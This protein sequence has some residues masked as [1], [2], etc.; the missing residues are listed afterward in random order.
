MAAKTPTR[1]THTWEIT[2][3]RER[4]RMLGYVEAPDL[5]TAI[6]VAIRDDEYD[7]LTQD[8]ANCRPT[9]IAGGN[10]AA[11]LEQIARGA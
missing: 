4:G 9:T 7:D 5:Q 11:A 3:I 2:L 10:V 6:N 8:L 1:K